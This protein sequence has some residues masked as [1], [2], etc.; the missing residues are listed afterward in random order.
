MYMYTKN[1]TEQVYP[2]DSKTINSIDKKRNNTPIWFCVTTTRG[3]LSNDKLF[4]EAKGVGINGYESRVYVPSLQ[5]PGIYHTLWLCCG[6]PERRND[7]RLV[8]CWHIRTASK[9]LQGQDAT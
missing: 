4:M 2:L 9:S 8:W 6:D 7:M 1:S 5:V 3:G